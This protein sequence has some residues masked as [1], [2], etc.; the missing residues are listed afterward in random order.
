MSVYDTFGEVGRVLDL[1]VTF[2]VGAGG[3]TLVEPL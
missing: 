2:G 1:S 3:S